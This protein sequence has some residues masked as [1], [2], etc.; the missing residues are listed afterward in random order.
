MQ[1]PT[2][3]DLDLAG[4]KEVE[5]LMGS[6][7]GGKA[8]PAGNRATTGSG[9]GFNGAA[10]GAKGAHRLRWPSCVGN[11][12]CAERALSRAASCRTHPSR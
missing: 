10:A 11:E 6:V 4:A 5:G 9:K 2:Y 7:R 3:P 1:T 8:D 12:C